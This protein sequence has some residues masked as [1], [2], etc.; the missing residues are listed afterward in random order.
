MYQKTHLFGRNSNKNPSC[1]T[2]PYHL[3]LYNLYIWDKTQILQRLYRVHFARFVDELAGTGYPATFR[4]R[5]RCLP[6]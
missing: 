3:L 2:V 6:N 4:L 5:F 1:H